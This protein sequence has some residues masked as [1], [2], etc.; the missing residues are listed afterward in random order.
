MTHKRQALGQDGE[1][2]ACAELARR[3]YAIL[4]RRYRT[5][6]G[7]ID[8]IT[9]DG[10]ALVFVEVRRKSAGDFGSAAESVTPEKQR[11]IARM[12]VDYLAHASL[13]DKCIVRFDVVAIDDQ[14]DGPPRLTVYPGAFETG[15]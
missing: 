12:A 1:E 2:L 10:E 3:G 13:I 15:R 7:E 4:E 5:R 9:R 6:Y 11:R 8:I 14:P